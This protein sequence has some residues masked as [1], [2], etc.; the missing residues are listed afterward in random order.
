MSHHTTLS[1][2]SQ[3]KGYPNFDS[4]QR[5]I[6][7]RYEPV[8]DKASAVNFQIDGLRSA[9]ILIAVAAISSRATGPFEY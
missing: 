5:S 6:I 3:A 2:P 9:L 4:C 8:F 7:K 1:T